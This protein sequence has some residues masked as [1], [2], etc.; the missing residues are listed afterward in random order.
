M[1][2]TVSSRAGSRS[3]Y[4]THPATEKMEADDAMTRLEGATSRPSVGNGPRI[5]QYPSLGER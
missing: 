2:N 4:E 3:R 5:E 1:A